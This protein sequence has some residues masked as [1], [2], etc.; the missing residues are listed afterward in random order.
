VDEGWLQAAVKDRW[1]DER[2]ALT[3]TNDVINHCPAS[4]AAAAAARQARTVQFTS[5]LNETHHSGSLALIH[6][7]H[8]LILTTAL[9]T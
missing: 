8:L 1:R 9:Q 3:S 4:A 7:K 5:R 6:L 2:R